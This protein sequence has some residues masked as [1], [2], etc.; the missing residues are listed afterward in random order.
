LKSAPLAERAVARRGP[1]GLALA[2][3]RDRLS[4]AG[5]DTP[6]LDAELLLAAILGVGRERL[7]IDRG[8]VLPESTWRRFEELLE[9][10]ADREPVAYI[11]GRRAFRRLTLSVDRRVLIPRPETELLV[12]VALTL[13]NGAIVVDVGTGSGAVALA[14]KDE[15]ADLRVRGTDISEDALAVARANG[16]TLGLEVEFVVADL[17]DDGPTD[18]VLA[19]LPY[20]PEGASLAPEITRYEPAQALFAGADGLA[21]VRRLVSVAG[22]HGVRTIALEIGGPEQAAEVTRLLADG[23]WPR[24]KVRRDLAGLDRVVVGCA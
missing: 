10:R 23:G 14:V 8:E 24:V 5:C 9:R 2:T 16:A 22:S 12:E 7:V 11:L 1:V 20:L 18:A 17:L 4:D 13:P 6:R 15:R 19:N 21:L 3:G